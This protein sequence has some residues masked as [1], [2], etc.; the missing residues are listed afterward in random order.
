MN[1]EI[2]KTLVENAREYYKNALDAEKKGDYNTS[3]TL[4]F[5]AISALADLYIYY[6]EKVIPSNHADRFR[7][8]ETKYKEVY[9]IVA[10]LPK[11]EKFGLTDQLKRSAISIVLNI[12]EGTV[13]LGDKEFKSY[14][15]N[16]L[17]SLYE[18][19][20]G[21]KLATKLFKVEINGVLDKCDLVGKELNALIKSLSKD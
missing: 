6:K 2:E 13:S 8:L 19:A 20:A 10:L 17:K 9:K 4:F 11:T 12:A 14:L 15:R 5:K 18:T 16:S 21:L 7:I 3:V 1:N